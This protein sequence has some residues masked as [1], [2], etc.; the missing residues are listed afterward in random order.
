MGRVQVTEPTKKGN[1]MTTKLDERLTGLR[2]LYR[3]MWLRDNPGDWIS[4][5]QM[6]RFMLKALKEA[7]KKPMQDATGIWSLPSWDE[8]IR[9]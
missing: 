8:D 4:A 9:Q 1:N 5:E 2:N 7:G 3:E 6:S